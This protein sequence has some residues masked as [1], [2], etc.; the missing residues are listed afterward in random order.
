MIKSLLDPDWVKQLAQC[1]RIFVGFSGG[2]DSTVLLHNLAE[3]S[4]LRKKLVAVHVNHGLS[5]HALLWEE[6]CQRFCNA[7]GLPLRIKKVEVDRQANIEEKARQARYKIFAS[8][9]KAGDCLILGHHQDDQAE[10]LLLQLF[11]G[12]GVGG[13][14]AMA[15]A[16]E[17]MEGQLLRPLLQHSRQTLEN[18]ANWYQLQWIDDESNEDIRFSRNY[19]RHQIIPL[20]QSR[21]PEVVTCLARS[22]NHC[23]QA[24]ANLDD[25]AKIDCPELSYKTMTLSLTP[26]LS[27]SKARIDNVL[28]VWLKRHQLRLPDTVTFNRLI[29]EVIDARGDANP[30]VSWDN[31]CI[32]RYQQTLYLL[33]NNQA[34]LPVSLP[35]SFFPEPLYL[36]GIGDLHAK[37]TNKGLHCPEHSLL[38]IR[39]RQG[40]ELFSWHGQTKRLK[41]LF[42]EWSIPPWLRDRIPLLYINSQLACVVGYAVSDLFYREH[43][44]KVYQIRFNC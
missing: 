35:W 23:Q 25:L 42:Q 5:M 20:L 26:L 15:T 39:F 2:L 29:T 21:W 3:Q 38:E 33:K 18:Y 30:Q 31:V 8:L 10:T 19:L 32:R 14:S 13:L 7:S 34:I 28:R 17:F 27:L 16:K 43:C 37:L 40:G 12:A 4:E 44:E 9:I 6:H 11:R 1:T 22:A 36:E 41:K 24:E